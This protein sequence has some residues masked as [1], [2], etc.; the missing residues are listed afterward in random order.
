MR[1][2]LLCIVSLYLVACSTTEE[3]V[4]TLIVSTD[5][6]DSAPVSQQNVNSIPEVQPKPVK[7]TRAGNK[8]PYTVL[9]KTYTLLTESKGYQERGKA[10]WYGTK[11]HGRRT[12]N[13]EVYD[14]WAM[15]A[16]H[17]TLPIPSYVRVTNVENGRSLIVLVNDRGPFHG[18]RIIDLSYGAAVKLGFAEKGV[19]TVDVIDVTPDGSQATVSVAPAVS[20]PSKKPPK[21]TSAPASTKSAGYFQ[22][23]AFQQ[24]EKANKLK[25]KLSGLLSSPVYVVPNQENTWYRVRVGPIANT[26]MMS[27]ARQI[28]SE[29]GIKNPQLIKAQ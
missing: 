1:L 28:L 9:G 12:A 20:I 11:F 21:A 24:M 16:A 18:D 8:S 19:T 23:A 22:V 2:L 5:N 3:R 14:M 10:S 4:P 15:T 26:Q 25:A 29:Q 6:N 27:E 13:G 7:R 17:K